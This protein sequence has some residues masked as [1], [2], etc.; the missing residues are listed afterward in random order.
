MSWKILLFDSQQNEIDTYAV[1][2]LVEVAG[3][4]EMGATGP[5]AV[6]GEGCTAVFL[7]PIVPPF[8]VKPAKILS[9]PRLSASNRALSSSVLFSV[10]SFISSTKGSKG[11]GACGS[12]APG[13]ASAGGTAP[14]VSRS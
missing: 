3:G 9:R 5:P 4:A 6:S 12:K 2:E 8:A 7:S 11:P 13:G 10:N 14:I 1:F